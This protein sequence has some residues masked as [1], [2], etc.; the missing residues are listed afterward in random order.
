MVEVGE[1]DALAELFG[2]APMRHVLDMFDLED[3][4]FL[5]T[6]SKKFCE[7][8]TQTFHE[9]VIELQDEAED[10]AEVLACSS[11]LR[12]I[13]RVTLMNFT[14]NQQNLEVVEDFVNN[15]SNSI[16]YLHLSWE[17]EGDDA[18]T[19]KYIEVLSKITLKSFELTCYEDGGASEFF[20][21]MAATD[22]GW[23]ASVKMLRIFEIYELKEKETL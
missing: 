12:N 23:F 9:V 3:K 19:A 2:K 14:I 21:Q 1:N 4:L 11:Q 13:H 18:L 7:K 5:R 6:V 15:N 17:G 8:V 16:E 20:K 22:H 10:Q